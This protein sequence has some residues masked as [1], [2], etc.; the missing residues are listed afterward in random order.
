MEFMLIINFFLYF[1]I[2]TNNSDKILQK[3]TMNGVIGE[4]NIG[5]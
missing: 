4:F 3:A 1:W 5:L 2:M